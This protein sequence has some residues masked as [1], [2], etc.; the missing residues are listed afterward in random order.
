MKIWAKNVE[1]EGKSN[2]KALSR[3]YLTHLKKKENNNVSGAE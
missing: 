1:E 2:A 3:T